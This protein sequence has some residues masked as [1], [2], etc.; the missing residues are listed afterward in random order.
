MKD[1]LEEIFEKNPVVENLFIPPVR[2]A[3]YSDRTA[4]LMACMAQAAYYK[5]EGE[6]ELLEWVNDLVSLKDKLAK[7]KVEKLLREFRSQIQDKS[8]KGEEALREGLNLAGIDLINTYNEGDTQAFLAKVRDQGNGSMLVLAFRGTEPNEVRDW[9]TNLKADLVPP[10][11]KGRLGEKVHRGFDIA[12]RLVENQ[13]KADLDA[14]KEV[15]ETENELLPPLYVTGHSLGGALAVMATRFIAKDSL[16]AC[17]TFGGPRVANS[18]LDDIMFTPV[19]RV[20]NAADVVARVPPS[21]AGVQITAF[22]LEII[23]IPWAGMYLKRAARTLRQRYG[24]Y[25]HFGD[26]RYLNHVEDAKDPRLELS[27]NPNMLLRLWWVG[28]RLLATRFR[29][30]YQDHDVSKYRQKLREYA[31]RRTVEARKQAKE[32]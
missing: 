26:M 16:G 21:T 8:L 3:A 23:P 32:S 18:K 20:V 10:K 13:I 5:F 1:Q 25:I 9:V 11:Y 28:T 4:H 30:A 2:R 6:K 24:G 15:V 19:Y 12:F 14:L 22:I 27:A 29:A 7:D 31:I 17:Y